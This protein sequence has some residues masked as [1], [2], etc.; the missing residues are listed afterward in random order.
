MPFI[1][2]IRYSSDS[3]KTVEST[4][5]E[6]TIKLPPLTDEERKARAEKLD[7]RRIQLRK[8]REENEKRLELEREKQRRSSGK[9][10]LDAREKSQRAEMQQIAEE[11]RREKEDDRKAKERIKNIIAEDRERK[12]AEEVTM[13]F[14]QKLLISSWFIIRVVFLFCR[15]QPKQ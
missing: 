14:L 2:R 1:A 9:E 4:P 12:K 13:L 10:I 3:L 15:H 5:A 11:R 8:E 6:P 7:Q